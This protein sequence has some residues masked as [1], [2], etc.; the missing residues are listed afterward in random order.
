MRNSNGKSIAQ[1]LAEFCK[2]LSDAFDAVG[3]VNTDNIMNLVHMAT[4]LKALTDIDPNSGF[5]N[6]GKMIS[7]GIAGGIRDGKSEIVNAVVEVVEAGITAGNETADIHSPS[8]VFAEMG[9][10]MMSGLVQGLTDSEQNVTGTTED[11]VRTIIDTMQKGLS[12]PMKIGTN[13]FNFD[14]INLNAEHVMTLMKQLQEGFFSSEE[15]EPTITPILDLSNLTNA[16]E[17]IRQYLGG[18]YG[19][20][21]SG[22]NARAQAASSYTGPTEVVVQNPV[23]LSGVIGSI[24]NLQTDIINLQSA[25]YN[26]KLVLDTGVLAGCVTDDVDANLGRKWLMSHRRSE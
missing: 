17:R 13:L 9:G 23:E 25:I 5:A 12:L 8:R 19:L 4:G 24:S 20:D 18:G 7:A 3:T 15:T 21:L 10:F 11:V 14:D 6:L 16:G 1:N 26:M 2:D 22:V